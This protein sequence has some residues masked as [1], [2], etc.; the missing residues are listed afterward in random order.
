MLHNQPI[1]KGSEPHVAVDADILKTIVS[2][3][4]PD[5][6]GLASAWRE[7][8]HA[9]Q[10]AQASAHLLSAIHDIMEAIEDA[11]AAGGNIS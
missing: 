2:G 8:Y 11:E 1:A 9:C 6:V 4:E 5:V 3:F 7:F 10:A